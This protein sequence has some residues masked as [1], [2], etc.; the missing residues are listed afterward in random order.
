VQDAERLHAIEPVHV[1][2]IGSTSPHPAPGRPVI[3]SLS[4]GCAALLAIAVYINALQNPFV[5]DDF[6]LI[7][8]NSSILDLR[9]F[10]S[11]ILRDV[12]RP[13]VNISY[14]VDTRIWGRIPLGYH[15]TNL[16]LH[17]LN[18]MLVFWVALLA[19]DDR[20]RGTTPAWTAGSPA[21]IGWTTASIFAVHPMMTEAVG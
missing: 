7:V 8:E 9:N 5:Y 4:A 11:V 2:V 15:V 19:A 20:R 14:A 6:R 21:V 12:T 13:L 10:R 17:A 18:V 16:A 1:A 3:L